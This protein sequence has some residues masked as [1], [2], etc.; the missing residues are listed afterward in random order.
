[1]AA[2]WMGGVSRAPLAVQGRRPAPAVTPDEQ[3]LRALLLDCAADRQDPATLAVSG[4][5]AN[6]F[7]RHGVSLLPI[8]GLDARETRRLM[9]CWV[10]GADQILGLDWFELTRMDRHEPRADEIEDVAALLV[11]AAHEGRDVDAARWLAQIISVACLGADHLWQDLHLRSRADLSSL[12]QD[13]F[14]ALAARNTNNMKWKKFFYKQLC[15]RAELQ[16][17]KSPSCAACSD[18][19][20]CF[21]PEEAGDSTR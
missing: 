17:C 18:Y 16:I 13:W 7:A 6:A 21:G 1:M 14:P 11:D 4:V 2:I 15:E 8:P 20:L 9:R 12:L 5:L 19:A 10:A 3:G